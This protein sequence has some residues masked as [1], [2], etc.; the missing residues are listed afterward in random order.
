MKAEE[1]LAMMY[2]QYYLNADNL[3]YGLNAFPVV[4]SDHVKHEMQ[5]YK[6]NHNNNITVR[7]NAHRSEKSHGSSKRSY[8]FTDGT[9][10][11]DLSTKR[12]KTSSSN[13]RHLDNG[14]DLSSSSRHYSGRVGE[15]SAKHHHARV[16][17]G[18]LSSSSKQSCVGDGIQV[19]QNTILNWDVEEVLE[20]IKQ[21]DG[22]QPYVSVCNFR[23]L[24]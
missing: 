6:K 21:V 7:D 12:A 23:Y 4:G 15:S 14:L 10:P 19:F 3:A 18:P 13:S 11:L 22:C 5:G 2:K 1:H 9:S 24:T 20:L 16:H 17:A 8:P